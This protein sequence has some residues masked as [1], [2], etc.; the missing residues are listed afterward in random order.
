M[1]SLITKCIANKPS[2]GTSKGS[3]FGIGM[4]ELYMQAAEAGSA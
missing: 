1:N 3:D 4:A 2:Q